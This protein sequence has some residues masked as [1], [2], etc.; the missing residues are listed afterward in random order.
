MLVV[1]EIACAFLL[2]KLEALG[3]GMKGMRLIRIVSFCRFQCG[4]SRVQEHQLH[5]MGCRRSRQNPSPLET[6]LPKYTGEYA[7][8]M[9]LKRLDQDDMI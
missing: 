3:L 9:G 2:R 4:D 8:R 6:L 5:C 1:V 7:D